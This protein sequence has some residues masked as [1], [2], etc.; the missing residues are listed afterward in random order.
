MAFKRDLGVF[1]KATEKKK[2]RQTLSPSP[3]LL[4]AT[5]T[6]L[7]LGW[8]DTAICPR[9][10][11]HITACLGRAERATAFTPRSFWLS[12]SAK[13]TRGDSHPGAGAVGLLLEPP[14]RGAGGKAARTGEKAAEEGRSPRLGGANPPATGHTLQQRSQRGFITGPTLPH[15]AHTL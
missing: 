10:S 6:L 9:P 5:F 8:L 4:L 13:G 11:P 2:K 3:I 14:G 7:A 15:G 12:H 1:F